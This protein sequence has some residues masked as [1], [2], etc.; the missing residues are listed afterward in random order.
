VRLL[1]LGW[2]SPRFVAL[3]LATC[4]TK[5][6]LRSSIYVRCNRWSRQ[7]CL[8]VCRVEMQY[9]FVGIQH[10][11]QNH[12]MIGWQTSSFGPIPRLKKPVLF[13]PSR[14]PARGVTFSFASHVATEGLFSYG[15]FA[16]PATTW[17]NGCCALSEIVCRGTFR[18]FC[19][20]CCF[21]GS[22]CFRAAGWLW[23]CDEA[24]FGLSKFGCARVIFYLQLI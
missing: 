8:E 5:L 20:M 23:I 24:C 18:R 9:S 17:R 13:F 7:I 10:S 6:C 21:A 19:N 4:T 2:D 3:S 14:L 11:M 16:R 1:K 12:R 15:S 22:I